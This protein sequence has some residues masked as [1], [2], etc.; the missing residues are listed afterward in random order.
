MAF[1]CMY[2]NFNWFEMGMGGYILDIDSR[3]FIKFYLKPV[4]ILYIHIHN[5]F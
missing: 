1:A 4:F 2:M 5:I 3:E